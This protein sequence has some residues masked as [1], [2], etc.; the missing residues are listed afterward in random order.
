MPQGSVPGRDLTTDELRRENESLRAQLEHQRLARENEA[1]RRQLN[2]PL[3]IDYHYRWYGT[4][5]TGRPWWYDFP[6][7]TILC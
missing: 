2:A 1:L 3:P 4:G 6:P 5:T 7:G